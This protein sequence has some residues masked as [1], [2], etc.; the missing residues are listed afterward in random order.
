MLPSE[1][2]RAILVTKVPLKL[3]KF[4]PTI[5]FSVCLDADG[6]NRGV[7]SRYRSKRGIKATIYIYACNFISFNAV[8]D[9]KAS[10]NNNFSIRLDVDGKKHHH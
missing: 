7:R 4:P 1:F 8:V 10:P 6:L 5:I 9:D 2:K 3:L